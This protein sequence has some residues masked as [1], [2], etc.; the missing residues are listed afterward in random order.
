[1]KKLFSPFIIFVLL[2]VPICA[3]SAVDP[4]KVIEAEKYLNSITGLSGDFVQI[5][6]GKKESG[7]FS[8]FRPGRV[9]LD[10]KNLPVQ[11]ISDGTDLYFFDKSLDQITTV[12]LTSTPA[13]ILV[14]KHID[15]RNSDI[16]VSD[17]QK[18]SNT[19]SLKMHLR[20]NAGIGTMTVIFNNNPVKLN[21]WTVVDATGAKTEVAFNNL[22]TKTDFGK[23]YFQIQRHKTVS[24]SGGD[25]YYD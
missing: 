12:P 15:L 9:R 7:I 20:D 14:R 24:V 2:F 16:T 4:S 3:Y 18:D 22:K 25:S 5:A 6:N 11:L 13:G 19:F 23:N 17:T 8:M 1:M 10:Y 21:S